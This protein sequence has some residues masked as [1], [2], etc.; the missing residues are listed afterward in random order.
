MYII[1]I[2]YIYNVHGSIHVL[3][4]AYNYI[5]CLCPQVI[6][7]GCLQVFEP[8][9]LSLLISGVPKIDVNDWCSNTLV[10]AQTRV[11]IYIR[12]NCINPIHQTPLSDTTVYEI[13]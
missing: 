8:N 12:H 1:Y 13:Q 10:R 9:E 4:S 7:R 11:Y 5:L 2:L 6:P 3:C